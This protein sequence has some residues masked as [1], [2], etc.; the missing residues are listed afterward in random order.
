MKTMKCKAVIFVSMIALVLSSCTKDSDVEVPSAKKT[1]FVEN[2][3]DSSLATTGWT[4][5]AQIG[6]KLWSQSSYHSDG[7]A[8]FSSYQSGQPVNVS[9]LISPEINLD[10]QDGEKLFFQTCQDGFVKNSGNSLELFISTDYDGTNFADASWE[11]VDFNVADPTSVRYIYQDSG[12]LD[13]SR[14]TGTI[15]FAFKYMGTTSA[16]GGYQVDNIRIFY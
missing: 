7:Y 13:L 10:T 15:H 3:D 2:F 1:I 8:Q 9:W 5:V 6:T 16:S 12:I 4:S 14:Y 11:R